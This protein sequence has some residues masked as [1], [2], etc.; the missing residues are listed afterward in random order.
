MSMKNR[1]MLNFI[2]KHRLL[3]YILHQPID[4]LYTK[5]LGSKIILKVYVSLPHPPQNFTKQQKVHITFRQYA[6]NTKTCKFTSEGHK[7]RNRVRTQYLNNRVRTQY[8]SNR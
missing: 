5:S 6:N 2:C 3:L 1:K 4:V 8:L 7:P